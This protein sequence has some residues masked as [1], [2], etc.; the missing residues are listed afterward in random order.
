MREQLTTARRLWP[1]TAMGLLTIAVFVV[2]VAIG[3][4]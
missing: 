3:P 1:L 2:G 4:A